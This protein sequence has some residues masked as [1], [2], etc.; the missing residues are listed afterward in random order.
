M[1]QTETAQTTLEGEK[2]EQFNASKDA[3]S[4]FD[5]VCSTVSMGHNM[6]SATVKVLLGLLVRA[7]YR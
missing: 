4:L 2:T 5:I 3:V 7:H 6:K 1:F